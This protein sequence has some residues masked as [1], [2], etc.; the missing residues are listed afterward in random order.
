[1]Q[2]TLKEL[3]NGTEQSKVF[4]SKTKNKRKEYRLKLE[5]IKLCTLNTYAREIIFTNEFGLKPNKFEDMCE[6]T[7][8]TIRELG[9]K[10]KL[11]DWQP[12][13]IVYLV[14]PENLPNTVRDKTATK[15]V[16][17][18]GKIL[19]EMEYGQIIP[20]LDK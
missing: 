12:T 8:Q 13:K 20:I 1:M 14:S 4:I 2:I 18:S 10:Y 5:R 15:V 17:V 19:Q 6:N 16:T 9:Y 7:L 11:F 3:Q